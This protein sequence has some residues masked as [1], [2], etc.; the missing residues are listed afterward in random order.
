MNGDHPIGATPGLAPPP[1]WRWRR[2]L[3]LFECGSKP[4]RRDDKHIRAVLIYLSARTAWKRLRDPNPAIET[5]A[6]LYQQDGRRRWFLEALLLTGID[7]VDVAGRV[8]E[9]A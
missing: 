2:A 8:N 3:Q 6:A 5:A 9:D 4:G 1:D 7:L